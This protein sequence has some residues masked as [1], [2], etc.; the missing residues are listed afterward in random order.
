M[1]TMVAKTPKSV[2]KP[3]AWIV[4]NNQ[5][6][7]SKPSDRGR[8]SIKNGKVYLDDGQEF[9]I[10]LYNPL[11]E[12]ILCDIKL[13]GK[14]I[15]KNGLILKPGQ[16]FYLDCFID[17]KKKFIF[18]T[19]DV[20]LSLESIEATENNG[21]LE[22]F[23]Y[24]EQVVNINNWKDKFQKVII[25]RYPV[26]YPYYDPYWYPYRPTVIYGGTT[27]IGTGGYGVVNTTLSSPAIGTTTNSTGSLFTND[28]NTFTS[29]CYT[30]NGSNNS[31]V[32]GIT[33]DQ[34]SGSDNFTVNCANLSNSFETGRVE[35]GTSSSQSFTEVDMDFET[36]YIA[37]TVIQLLPTSRKPVETKEIVNKKTGE[38]NLKDIL[39]R[40]SDEIVELIKKLADLH[41]A[42][43]LTDE[44]FSN[45]KAELLSKI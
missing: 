18:N 16:R 12:C 30:S 27:T 35:K 20:E 40:E 25:E 42:G 10:E 26:Y 8:K 14:K 23:F 11:K 6:D 5:K 28:S 29:A 22:V 38:I 7:K 4:V 21:S 41:S 37:S 17:D 3:D 13:N 39:V 9:E 43:I 45:K 32:Y 24:K 1:N 34:I 15:K 2:T 33:N 19:Y 44:E 36:N 31:T